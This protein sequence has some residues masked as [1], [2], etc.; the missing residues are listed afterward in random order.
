MQRLHQAIAITA[1]AT[2]LMVAP[3]LA[4][5]A[6]FGAT[7][8]HAFGGGG[9]GAGGGGGGGGPGGGG[10]GSAGA[11]GGPGAAGAAGAHGASTAA[12]ATSSQTTGLGKAASVVGTT[13]GADDAQSGLG[14]ASTS[15]S[16]HAVQSAASAPNGDR[17]GR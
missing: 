16:E 7:P 17:G 13:P 8:A 14:T 9:G 6:G 2:F 3:W 11:D 15:V 5:P 12:A 10:A 4:G 1:T